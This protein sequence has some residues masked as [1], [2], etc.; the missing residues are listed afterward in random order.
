MRTAITFALA[1]VLVSCKKDEPLLSTRVVV[2][3]RM[4]AVE[5][6]SKG[7]LHRDTIVGLIRP[8]HEPVDTLPSTAT[9]NLTRKDG[10]SLYAMGCRLRGTF[11]DGPI[12]ID[13]SGDV[14]P[15][16]ASGQ[17][18][19]ACTVVDQPVSVR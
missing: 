4:C 5:Y 7:E 6:T 19:Q 2:T 14:D 9:W 3:C 18:P 16:N 13:V 17:Y 11:D 8:F 12:T 15:I 1:L 10:E